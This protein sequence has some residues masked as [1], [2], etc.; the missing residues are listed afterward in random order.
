[1]NNKNELHIILFDGTCNLCSAIV[2]FIYRRDSESK[3][4]FASLES[5]AG[6]DLLNEN[7]LSTSDFDSLVYSKRGT[8]HIK[9][10]AAL[11]IFKNLGG[12]WKLLFVCIVV[13]RFTRDFI[14]DLIAKNRYKVFG[15]SESCSISN[16]DIRNRFLD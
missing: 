1:M 16:L 11:H 3:F 10:S 4:Y 2:R 15:Q 14:Y 8:I 5:R 7:N 12:F 6:Q 13:P 9:S